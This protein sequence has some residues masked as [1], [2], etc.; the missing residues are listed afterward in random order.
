[1]VV[2]RLNGP[3]DADGGDERVAG[4]ERR[5]QTWLDRNRD[6]LSCNLLPGF[7]RYKTISRW[8]G[9]AGREEPIEAIEASVLIDRKNSNH[10]RV[11]LA[12][13]FTRFKILSQTRSTRTEA[14]W[15]SIQTQKRRQTNQPT[16]GI[17]RRSNSS[18]K[19]GP[20]FAPHQLS[21]QSKNSIKPGSQRRRTSSNHLATS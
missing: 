19:Q 13:S 3:N 14:C 17:D 1:L 20:R 11:S 7:F 12:P 16:E 4:G 10:L 8:V 9:R 18:S 6:G 15:S 21:N 5:E 2:Y